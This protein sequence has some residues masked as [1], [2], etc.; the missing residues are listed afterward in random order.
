M[1]VA[2]AKHPMSRYVNEQLFALGERLV[3]KL[4]SHVK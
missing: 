4:N 2:W 3:K 1:V